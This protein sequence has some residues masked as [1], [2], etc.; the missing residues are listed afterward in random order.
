MPAP[1]RP[2]YADLITNQ[3]VERIIRSLQKLFDYIVIDTPAS[4][5][6]NVLMALDLATRIKLVLTLDL[7]S[8]K[9][10]KLCLEVLEGL[11]LKEKVR[12]ILNNAC[13]D[14]GLRAEDVER[15]LGMHVLCELPPSSKVVTGA[16]N[17]G[18][19]YYP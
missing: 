15:T 4:F 17:R 11:G 6:E 7:P 18:H 9:N 10:A 2:Q 8:I 13:E 5:N 3:H 14:Y 1:T 19:L 16:V 12:V